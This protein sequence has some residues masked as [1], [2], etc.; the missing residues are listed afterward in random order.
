MERAGQAGPLVSDGQPGPVTQP[1]PSDRDPR[2]TGRQA[3]GTGR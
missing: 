1:A 3:D 2:T